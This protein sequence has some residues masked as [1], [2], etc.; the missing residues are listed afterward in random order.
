M[1]EIGPIE[2][3]WIIVAIS[4][5]YCFSEVKVRNVSWKIDRLVFYDVW[6][7]QVNL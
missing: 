2:T 3:N 4:F 6:Q 5:N 7:M 1:M